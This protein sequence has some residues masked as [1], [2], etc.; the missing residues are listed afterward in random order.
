MKKFTFLIFYFICLAGKAQITFQK[1]YDGS[2]NDGGSCVRQTNDNGYI[3]TGG[4]NNQYGIG[5]DIYLVKTDF[6][7]NSQWSKSFS[8]ASDDGGT[9]VEQTSDG[10]FIITGATVTGTGSSE[11]ILLKT[12][13]DGTVQWAKT[14]GGPDH[15][16]GVC[17]QQTS[18][19]GYI[20]IGTTYSFGAG[21]QFYS[22]IY[23]LK[24]DSCGTLQWSK[25]YGNMD[26]ND[27]GSSILQTDDGGF[28][29]TGIAQRTDNNNR[30]S[31]GL[32]KIMQNGNLQWAK[33]FYGIGNY[34]YLGSSI[35]QCAD[36]G[37]ILTGIAQDN[38][39]DND[40][41]AIVKTD[42]NGYLQWS[43]TF[44]DSGHIYGYGIELT[45]DNGFIISGFRRSL[46]W[47]PDYSAYLAKTDSDGLIQW[48]KYYNPF[49]VYG[50][51]N[52]Q[53]T[54][55]GGFVFTA[56]VNRLNYGG[57]SN[58]SDVYLVKTDSSGNSDCNEESLSL[59]ETNL[60]MLD[61]ILQIQVS[62]GGIEN[63]AMLQISS[64]CQ[65]SLI[66]IQ[67][68][69]SE[70][71]QENKTNVF[72]NPSSGI[73]TVQMRDYLSEAKIIVHDVLGNCL[74]EKNCRGETSQEINLSYQP[75]GVYFMEIVAGGERVLKKIVL[76]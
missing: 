41:I 39:G 9:W 38:P 51:K 62:S 35:K 10:G 52:A 74:F 60:P 15:D 1:S 12:A 50:C 64:G 55:D 70:N 67:L 72:P 23:I 43:K 34:S 13:S 3:I 7:G 59:T 32:I 63:S 2:G 47:Y 19:G 40:N 37:Y 66:C 57:P 11:V 26:C 61:S 65:D 5:S 4:T 24:T 29:I 46:G 42:S 14:Y 25:T 69:V 48:A 16:N 71:N 58:S 76:Q 20:V 28:I 6:L 68:N 49:G 27:A 17:V 75:K 22:D 31:I 53:Q 33:R 56:S 73:I 54:N 18:E 30:N 45:N 44:G 8:G 36:K 21:P